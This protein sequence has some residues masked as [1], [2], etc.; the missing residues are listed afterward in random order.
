MFSVFT[1]NKVT[2]YLLGSEAEGLAVYLTQAL[3]SAHAFCYSFLPVR[4]ST[5]IIT[6]QLTR[7]N[8]AQTRFNI[9]SSKNKTKKKLKDIN[10]SAL[11]FDLT[12]ITVKL[13][14]FHMLIKHLQCHIDNVTF[15]KHRK[16]SIRKPPNITQVQKSFL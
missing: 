7:G 8:T 13:A 14:R 16:R 12:D 1:S 9:R 5:I 6:G 4:V 11:C 15:I 3:C 10:K 2:Y